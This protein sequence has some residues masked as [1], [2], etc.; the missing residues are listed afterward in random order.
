[1]M[2]HGGEQLMEPSRGCL[3]LVGKMR[4]IIMFAAAGVLAT[5]QASLAQ[6]P[7]GVRVPPYLPIPSGAAVIMDT[8][9]TNTP[10]YRIVIT[11]QGSLEYASAFKQT[12]AA[13][14]P[15]LAHTF[16]SDL[17]KAAPLD[18]LPSAPCMKSVSFGSSLFVWS[19]KAG[20][21][22]DLLCPT[23]ERGASL[24]RDAQQIAREL[25]L[26]RPGAP[27]MRPLAPGE[28]HMPIPQGSPSATL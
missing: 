12:T 22:P 8:G 23:D 4:C 27:V 16:F 14:S 28:Q 6:P 20:R 9:S 25:S 19:R 1:M 3:R 26:G 11:A 2:I 10:A 24:A 21:S 18:R 17:A 15:N 13:V 7:A 5:V